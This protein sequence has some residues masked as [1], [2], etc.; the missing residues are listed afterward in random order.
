MADELLSVARGVSDWA[1]DPVPAPRWSSGRRP[2]DALRA[3]LLAEPGVVLTVGGDRGL[4]EAAAKR[5]VR[6][7]G[8]SDPATLLRR[9][10]RAVPAGAAG[11]YRTRAWSRDPSMRRWMVDVCYIPPETGSRGQADEGGGSTATT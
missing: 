1:G 3:T 9:S 4:T 2:L 8:R 11:K 6:S 10:G 7:F 5:V